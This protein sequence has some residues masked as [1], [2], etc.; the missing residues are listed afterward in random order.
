[1]S[2]LAA[3]QLLFNDAMIKEG[4]AVLINNGTGGIGTFAI[5]IAKAHGCYVTASAS[6][7]N[8]EFV[9]KLGADQACFP[10]L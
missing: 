4:D 8:H 10:P 2:G 6:S 9:K 3:L 7:S 1:M 5:Q